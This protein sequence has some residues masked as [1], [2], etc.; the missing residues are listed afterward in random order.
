[1]NELQILNFEDHRLRMVMIDGD[2]WWS[3][4]DVAE[5]LGYRNTKDAIIS[6]VDEEDKQIVQRSENPTIENHISNRS[7]SRKNQLH[8]IDHK[9]REHS[10][11]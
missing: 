8:K 7:H 4:R 6:H 3:G 2:L 1:M 11:R 10:K 5:V 9:T